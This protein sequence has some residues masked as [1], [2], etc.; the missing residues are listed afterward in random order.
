MVNLADLRK[1][2]K[3]E[4]KKEE[5][6]QEKKEVKENVTEDFKEVKQ[7]VKEKIPP[8][9]IEKKIEEEGEKELFLCF[10]IGKEIYG[11]QIDYIQEIIPVYPITK[12]PNSPKEIIGIISIRGQVLPVL[13]IGLFL[14][15]KVEKITEDTKLI[16]LRVKDE[17][18]SIIVDKVYQNISI[19]LKSIE[20]A[21]STVK[22][23]KGLIFGVYPFKKR[24]LIL[25]KAE[26]I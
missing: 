4:E 13:D 25:L 23:E 3:K 15:Q 19:P 1:K 17:M 10:S 5:L 9:K 8:P 11:I 6:A 2:K 7:A 14:G 21:P 26:Q 18:V 24:L 16:I 12:V 20:Q 22:D